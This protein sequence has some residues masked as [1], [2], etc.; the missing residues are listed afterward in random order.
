M[1]GVNLSRCHAGSILC[2]KLD[3]RGRQAP[4]SHLPARRPSTAAG[5]VNIWSLDDSVTR[6]RLTVSLCTVRKDL[7]APYTSHQA[8]QYPSDP[9]AICIPGGTR[10][11]LNSAYAAADVDHAHLASNSDVGVP[12]S[13]LRMRALGGLAMYLD[14]GL[15]QTS[16]SI[17]RSV[18]VSHQTRRRPAAP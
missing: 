4:N 1:S 7:R 10:K 5:P 14:I 9:M 15:R 6:G 13:V 16:P 18:R 12:A 11:E 8:N 2:W 3:S 17:S